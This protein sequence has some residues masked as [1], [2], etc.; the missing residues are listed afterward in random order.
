VTIRAI[1]GPPGSGKTAY[2]T[3]RAQSGELIVD[4]DALFHALSGLPWYDKPRPLLKYVLAAR[5]G[6]MDELERFQN[7][8]A[9]II[10]D[11]PTRAERNALRDRFDAEV[12]V[13]ETPS[14]VCLER[15]AQDDRRP[16]QLAEWMPRVLSWWK[17]Y[18][19]DDR[20]IVITP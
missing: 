18:E 6:A 13:L 10:A 7:I 12:T 19:K 3:E 20:D 8:G 1:C 4:V 16:G 17:R 5:D 2:V 9:W 14:G 11:A 15:L